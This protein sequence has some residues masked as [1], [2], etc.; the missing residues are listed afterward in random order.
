MPRNT[1][2][3]VCRICGD[4]IP[5]D[6][7]SLDYRCDACVR[8]GKQVPADRTKWFSKLLTE[9]NHSVPT[10][11]VH[12]TDGLNADLSDKARLAAV[13][14]ELESRGLTIQPTVSGTTVLYPTPER[15][16]PP[17]TRAL[18]EPGVKSLR[19]SFSKPSAGWDAWFAGLP[20]I[21]QLRS[22]VNAAS[23]LAGE[24]RT[25][26]LAECSRLRAKIAAVNP[27]PTPLDEARSAYAR[28]LADGD[29]EGMSRATEAIV[30][31]KRSAAAPS[32]QMQKSI[33]ADS[34]AGLSGDPYARG[35][36]DKF[37]SKKCVGCGS[38]FSTRTPT[39]MR[40]NDC[41]GGSR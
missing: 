30:R 23:A 16:G 37:Q 21:Q 20:L 28:A 32:P 4:E 6:Q 36:A 15:G 13:N 26:A 1:S 33:V 5:N 40:C 19:G 10:H 11:I 38:T 31:I 3:D 9:R 7:G 41:L 25:R 34:F 27:P 22:F 8:E 2:G 12:S 35:Q 29:S 24:A 17:I 14:A 18:T 39:R